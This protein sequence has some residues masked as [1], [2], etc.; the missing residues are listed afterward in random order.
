M[1]CQ[2]AAGIVSGAVIGAMIAAIIVVPCWIEQRA[3]PRSLPY[4]FGDGPFI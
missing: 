4:P 1:L 2:I 3:K